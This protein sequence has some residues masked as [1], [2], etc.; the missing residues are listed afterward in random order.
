MNPHSRSLVAFETARAV[1]E[2]IAQ[3]LPPQVDPAALTVNSKLPFKVLSLRELLI[4]RVSA[5]AVAAVDLHDKGNHLAAAT[6]TRSILETTA[7]AFAIEKNLNKFLRVQ[8]VKALDRFLM[9]ILIAS[10]A[11]DANHPA[12]DITGLVNSVNTRKPG[13]KDSYNQL[14]EY[15]H[16]NWAGLL[17]TFGQVDQASLILSLG[18]SQ[19]A[20][21]WATGV[22]AL[23]NSLEE[24]Q[25]IYASLGPLT[26]QLNSY[27][28]AQSP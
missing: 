19:Y 2:A 16:P 8:D 14:C 17:G 24:F 27:F 28:E 10:G 6:I 4:H 23:V 20:G 25:R 5:L 15:V 21:A 18:S 13:F 1:T 7:V 11:P 12:I 3:S 22:D 26:V 9:K